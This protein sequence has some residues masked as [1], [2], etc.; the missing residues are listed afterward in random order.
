MNYKK[1][2]KNDI[3][4][5]IEKNDDN[6]LKTINQLQFNKKEGFFNMKNKKL[7][8]GLSAGCACAVVVGLGVG[9]GVGLNQKSS[10]EATSM[11]TMSL[12]PQISMVLDE[13]NYVLSVNGDNNEGKIV[14]SGENLVG[15][16]VD[17]VVAK[18]I[19]IESECGYL[20][21]GQIEAG[22]N[23]LTVDLTVDNENIK[24]TIKSEIDKAINS[25]CNDLNIDKEIAYT[26]S[27]TKEAL[28]EM[29][30]NIDP[31]LTKEDCA[32]MSYQEKLSR[33]AIYQLDTAEFY[34][35]ELEELYNQSKEYEV[36]F[37]DTEATKEVISSIGNTYSIIL[38]GIDYLIDSLKAS[39]TNLENVMYTQLV[40][41]NSNFQVSYNSFLEAKQNVIKL[42]N[43]VANS[44]AL[45][46]SE[47]EVLKKELE[48][49]EKIL[50][51]CIEQMDSY[52]E[53]ALATIQ[54]AKD[55]INSIID[56]IDK[57]IKELPNQDEV[58]STLSQ[59]SKQIEDK[60]NNAKKEAYENFE[61][62]YAADIKNA[63]DQALA[64]KE[65]LKNQLSENLTK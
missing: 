1:K 13:N 22:Q 21:S 27:I 58:E 48:A 44:E 14:I 32:D 7:V 47:K 26:N 29:V 54:T 36:K 43:E 28:I 23:K 5:S 4:N 31:S 53:S 61:K 12:N 35:V 64:Y 20:V 37:A 19:Q 6:Y 63:K 33:I 59:N 25:T 52:K 41:E 11:V 57:T 55:S 49:K 46:D 17:E 10:G 38:S 8:V 62:E 9:L 16:K 40:D 30:V 2:F 45:S 15:L 18:V 39:V 51:F 24:N 50:D 56:T 3:N 60:I 42:K 34:T 65:K